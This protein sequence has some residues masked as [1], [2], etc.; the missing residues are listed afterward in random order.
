M[1]KIKLKNS[2]ADSMGSQ[3]PDPDSQSGSEFAIRIRSYNPNPNSQSE[4]EFAIRIRIRNPEPDPG[5]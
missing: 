2:V 3:D 1:V 4:S 5:Q